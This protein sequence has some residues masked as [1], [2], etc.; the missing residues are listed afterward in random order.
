MIHMMVPIV[1]WGSA[2]ASR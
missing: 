2:L 1:I